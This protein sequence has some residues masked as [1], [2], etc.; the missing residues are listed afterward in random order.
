VSQVK[1][2]AP[3]VFKGGRPKYPKHL[4]PEAR[5]EFKRCVRMLEDRGTITEGDVAT[6]A[7]YAELLA[8]W[9]Q[10]KRE[11]GKELMVESI[12]LDNNGMPHKQKKLNP[13]LKVAATCETRLLAL[14]KSLGLTPIDRDKVKRTVD[15]DT[16][17]KYP[18]GSMGD[19]MERG[20]VDGPK[21]VPI[22]I[23]AH[24]AE[25]E[26]NRNVDEPL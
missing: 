16:E 21:V 6:L 19:L 15:S 20:L 7:V 5:S 9:I 24:D 18:E 10:C 11:I 3:S 2:P 22:D 1:P 13:L 12:V 25:Q 17:E 26:E 23:A 14:A 8:R 4:S